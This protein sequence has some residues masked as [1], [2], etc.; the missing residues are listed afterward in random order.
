MPRIGDT[1]D[2]K[3]GIQLTYFCFIKINFEDLCRE[4]GEEGNTP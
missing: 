4:T 1:F 2:C 3:K